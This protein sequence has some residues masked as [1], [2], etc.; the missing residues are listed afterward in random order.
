MFLLLYGKGGVR[1]PTMMKL[2]P[3]AEEL[4][5]DALDNAIEAAGLPANTRRTFLDDLFVPLINFYDQEEVAEMLAANGITNYV[6]WEQG[7]LDHE[8]SAPVQR[9]ELIRL[10][11]VFDHADDSERAIKPRRVR[12]RSC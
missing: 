1:W 4:G 8:Q 9:G 3:L 12:S 5:Y 2:R 11:S 6:R 10:K 7:K